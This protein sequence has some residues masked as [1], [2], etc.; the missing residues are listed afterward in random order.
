[1]DRAA[2][3]EE[4]SVFLTVNFIGSH[5]SNK[6]IFILGSILN[7]PERSGILIPKNK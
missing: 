4:N 2:Y 7:S 3:I 1:M 5:P 6:H